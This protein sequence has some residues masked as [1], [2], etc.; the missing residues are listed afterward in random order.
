MFYFILIYPNISYKGV[1]KCKVIRYNK[2]RKKI[3]SQQ[4][5]DPE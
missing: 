4:T 1:D 2:H 3:G 5:V